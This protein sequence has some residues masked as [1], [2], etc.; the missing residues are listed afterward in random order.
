MRRH[1]LRQLHGKY[2][3]GC[4]GLIYGFALC[5]F[6]IL[7]GDGEGPGIRA[8]DFQRITDAANTV[9]IQ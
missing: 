4:T 1:L 5:V 7:G 2:H 3:L 6:N 8:D 9:V